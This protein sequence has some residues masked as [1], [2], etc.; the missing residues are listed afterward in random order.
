[1]VEVTTIFPWEIELAAPSRSV[2]FSAGRDRAPA[3]MC[4]LKMLS[5]RDAE[6][7]IVLVAGV[8][9]RHSSFELWVL[10][11]KDFTKNVR[12]NVRHAQEGFKL[13]KD[14]FSRLTCWTAENCLHHEKFAWWFGFHRIGAI[15]HGNVRYIIHGVN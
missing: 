8:W 13:L 11:G 14:E 4:A 6:G 5:I 10:L 15:E 12:A 2:F 7:A 3:I 9:L 1:M